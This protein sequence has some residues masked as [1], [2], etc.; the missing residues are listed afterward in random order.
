[1]ADTPVSK[2]AA[3]ARPKPHTARSQQP[4]HKETADER[5][6]R[7]KNVVI[8]TQIDLKREAAERRAAKAAANS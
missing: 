3:P 5:R 8:E 1:M 4:G 7:Q 2:P 6:A